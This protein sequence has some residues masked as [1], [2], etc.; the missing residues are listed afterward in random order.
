MANL[1]D[2]QEAEWL[3]WCLSF[4]AFVETSPV[5]VGNLV[6]GKSTLR[7]VYRAK[8]TTTPARFRPSHAQSIEYMSTEYSV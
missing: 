2:I 1:K 5:D 4:P 8:A 6:A 3:S 7:G